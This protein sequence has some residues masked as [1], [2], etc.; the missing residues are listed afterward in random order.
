MKAY[1]K[2]IEYYLPESVLTNAQIVEKFPEWTIE[3]IENK[4]GIRTR[5]V[6][7]ED[8]TASDLACQAVEKLFTG[9]SFAKESV[10]CLIFCSQSPDYILPSTACILQKRLGLLDSIAAYDVN[11][12]CSGWIYGISIAKGLVCSGISKNVLLVTAETYSKYLHPQD[13]GNRTI[14]GDGAAATLI[15]DNGIAEIGNFV[16]GTDGAGAENLIVKCGGARNRYPLNDLSFDDFGNPKSS[17]YLYMDGA[18]ILNYTL[19]RIPTLVYDV[20][21]K[22]D[23]GIEDIDLHIYHQANRYIANLQRRKLKIDV[24]KYYHCYEE[25]GNTVSSTIPIAIFE[26]LKDG[27]IQKGY[28]VLSVAQ[29][30]GYSWGGCVLTF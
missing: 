27:S 5:H 15:S 17:D 13:K 23:I 20:L 6:V 19:D 2:K 16:F 8:E 9:S 7:K 4:I 25:C 3:K 24:E 18:S 26:A 21:Q 22:N 11:L 29:G 12:G 28:K 30:L 1:I 14:F 10:D